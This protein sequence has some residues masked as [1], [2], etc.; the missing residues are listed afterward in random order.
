MDCCYPGPVQTARFLLFNKES[1]MIIENVQDQ[2]VRR[3]VRRVGLAARKSRSANPL[4]NAGGYT[5][6]DPGTGF[7]VAGAGFSMSPQE[8]IEFCAQ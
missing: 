3:A 2:R 5:L 6:F 4:D 8:A 7:P 1:A